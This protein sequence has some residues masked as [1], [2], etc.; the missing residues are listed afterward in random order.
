LTP[1]DRRITSLDVAENLYDV[2]GVKKDATEEQIR[3]AYRKLARKHHPDV[4]PGNK[5]AEEEFKKVASA[6][7]VLS[8]AD[9][10]K[11][12]DEFGE[13]SLRGGFDPAKARAYQ[14]WSQNRRQAGRPFEDEAVE[15]DLGDLFGAG[16]GGFGGDFGRARARRGLRGEDLLARV[17]IDLAQALTGVELQVTVPTRSDCPAC[18]GSGDQP[19]APV[20]TCATCGGSGKQQVAQGPMRMVIPCR[21]C[22]GDGK[23]STPCSTCGGAGE[24][25]GQKPI[26]V[27]IPPGADTGSRLRVAG[28]GAPG[29]A[30]GDPGD[31]V[32]ETVVRP[33]PFFRREGLDLVLRLPITLGEALGGASVEVPT[34][35][36]AV[37]LTVP[38][39][40]QPGTRLRLRGRGVKRGDKQ[41]DMYAE[42]E[43]RMP[44]GEDPTLVEAARAAERSYG[45]PVREG[46]RL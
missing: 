9:K 24:I 7:E 4:N 34:P 32:I 35:Q 20:T 23:I 46:L 29:M 38:P 11:A 8:S 12:Y 36:G 33:H 19:G 27:R 15:F 21:A 2:L 25:S 30:G 13:E 14:Q 44:D 40:S 41:G 16:A 42:I 45:K 26:T 10:R 37:K 43:L 39:R 6:Y 5:K 17:E 1:G 3:R 31:L 28:Q 22:G 18:R